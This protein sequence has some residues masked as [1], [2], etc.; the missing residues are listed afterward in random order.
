MIKLWYT[1]PRTDMRT[2]DAVLSDWLRERLADLGYEYAAVPPTRLLWNEGSRDFGRLNPGWLDAHR[3]ELAGLTGFHPSSRGLWVSDI[4]HI[5]LWLPSGGVDAAVATDLAHFVDIARSTYPMALHGL[6]GLPP[7]A[8]A[9]EH[10]YAKLDVLCPSIY[11]KRNK[12]GDLNVTAWK[13][14]LAE[15]SRIRTSSQWVV[16]FVSPRVHMASTNSLRLASYEEFI[17]PLQ[18]A[19]PHRVEG[20]VLWFGGKDWT[21]TRITDTPNQQQSE[22]AD[23]RA[24]MW[25][26]DFVQ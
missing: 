20:F 24:A 9:I 11:P 14:R 1:I 23:L 12:Q 6:Y 16:P 4:E 3:D 19:V 13:Q 26:K 7:D 22:L 17:A 18:E 5:S 15:T 25:L 10:I 8:G 21:S 2:G